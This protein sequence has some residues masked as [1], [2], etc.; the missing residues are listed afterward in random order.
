MNQHY[1]LYQ[2]DCKFFVAP[3][4]E[5]QFAAIEASKEVSVFERRNAY[6]DTLFSVYLDEEFR[7]PGHELREIMELWPDDPTIFDEDEYFASEGISVPYNF[8]SV[9][10]RDYYEESFQGAWEAFLKKKLDAVLAQRTFD[11]L[12]EKLKPILAAAFLE[13]MGEALEQEESSEYR[14]IRL[15]T[16]HPEYTSDVFL[17][18]M[19]A[20]A[21]VRRRG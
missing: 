14:L 4:N 19:R 6:D 2:T 12:F 10:D 11:S 1:L 18:Q 8:L 13:A 16:Q 17:E 9:I 15:T 5:E 3:L 7:F 21:R 20:V